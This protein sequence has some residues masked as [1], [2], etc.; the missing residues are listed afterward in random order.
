MNED[1]NP[2]I[3]VQDLMLQIR[4]EVARKKMHAADDTAN[5]KQ[6]I[7]E[8]IVLNRIPENK[9][10]I[11]DKPKYAVADFL[12][13]QDDDFIRS[14]YRGILRREPD[15][16]GYDHY[17]YLLYTGQMSKIEIL[18]R[19]RYSAEGRSYAVPVRGLLKPF[20]ARSAFRL[21][22]LGA[23]AAI[24]SAFVKLPAIVRNQV[25][26]E[27]YTYRH[28]REHVEQINIIADQIETAITQMQKSFV[29]LAQTIDTQAINSEQ[30]H[31]SL[32]GLTLALASKAGNEELTELNNH[33]VDL[34][35]RKADAAEL[36]TTSELLLAE[37][38]QKAGIVQLE[39]HSAASKAKWQEL[40]IALVAKANSTQLE[41]NNT[42]LEAKLQGLSLTLSQKADAAELATSS[43]QLLAEL[44]QKAGVA[45]LEAHN[46]A[47]EIQ[48][49]SLTLA[50]E[51]KAGNE[52]LTQLTNHLVEL[53]K[54]KADAA[55]LATTNAQLL[56]ELEQKAGVAQ[57]EA[58]SAASKT[59]LQELT[60]ALDTKANSTELEANNTALEAKLQDLSLILSQKAGAAELAATSEL[61]LA[62]LEQKAGIAQ[63]EAHS[64][65]S[66]TKLQELT[67][68]LDTKANS[69][70]LE[71]NN[72]ALEAKLQGISLTLERKADA[73]ATEQEITEIKRQIND[74]KHN[75]LDQHR[76]LAV[77]LEEAR[78]RLPATFSKTQLSKMVAEED[79]L[80]DAFYVSFEDQFRGTRV[81]IKQRV[82][83]YLPLLKVANA[84]TAKA[85]ILDIGCGRGEW[86]EVL[87]EQ[88]LIALGVDS[89]H[90]MV[91]QCQELG[92]EVINCDA[93]DYLRSLNAN[94]QGAVTGMHII[95]HIPFK[96]LIALL[97]EVLRVLKPGGVAI[98]ETPNPEN[99]IVGACNFYYDPTH[100]KPLPPEPM[101]FVLEA[102]G[103]GSIEILRLHPY[104][105]E[106]MLKEGAEQVQQTINS[107]MFGAQDYALVAYKS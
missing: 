8:G 17:G 27:N 59:K 30:I 23:T 25:S 44:E 51:T 93:V 84:G 78:K 107:L 5:L 63:L 62:E 74:Q 45:Q 9:V 101:R 57:L 16:S 102:R 7:H 86:L 43:A 54:R 41:A 19:L 69:T 53:I 72:T 52:Q 70:E 71:A 47:S 26:F 94:S 33:L 106:S 64:A 21:P 73:G 3:N 31:K 14:A 104:P 6:Y 80:L 42:A 56:A 58:H 29:S 48:Y 77:L 60:V 12:E 65:A 38:E 82:A 91:S 11:A 2:D 15:A 100:I 10:C 95:E 24:A 88:N 76:R 36:A 99:L 79:H 87:Q 28:Q 103:F 18:G 61:L 55:E 34:I 50:L 49:K 40:F 81:D 97:D 66:K 35:K 46:S 20:L 37:L 75:I 22:V 90:V 68:A 13:Y 92:L 83:V 105:E 39:A 1:N 85:P 96:R 32:Q 4:D 98:F 67:V 89:N